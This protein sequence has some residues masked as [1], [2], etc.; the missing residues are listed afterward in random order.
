MRDLS[1]LMDRKSAS[2]SPASW[3]NQIRAIATC[4]LIGVSVAYLC[5][6]CPEQVQ[7][8]V[9]FGVSESVFRYF[10]TWDLSI[11]RGGAVAY[12]LTV[13]S[14]DARPELLASL[15][16]LSDCIGAGSGFRQGE[17]VL[18]RFDRLTWKSYEEA[19]VDASVYIG[20]EA[21]AG[22]I[23]KVMRVN[24]RWQVVERR[25]TWVA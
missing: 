2:E 8:Q 5:Q 4:L 3:R 9:N 6:D 11:R 7:E 14:G 23:L 19:V 18:I 24:G 10:I 17:G 12:Y 22:Y 13:G 21:A 1:H 15:A 25:G 20:P 16:D